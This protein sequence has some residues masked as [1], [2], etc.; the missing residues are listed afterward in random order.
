MTAY[1]LRPAPVKPAKMAVL[2]RRNKAMAGN[3]DNSVKPALEGPVPIEK[4][5]RP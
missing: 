2:L 3:Y 1:P 5:G 4:A